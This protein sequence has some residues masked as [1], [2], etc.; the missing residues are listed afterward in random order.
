[1]LKSDIAPIFGALTIPGEF[2]LDRIW[3]QVPVVLLGDFNRTVPQP[4]A[5]DED[6]DAGHQQV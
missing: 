3:D 2:Y 1:M 5:D 6:I 4:A